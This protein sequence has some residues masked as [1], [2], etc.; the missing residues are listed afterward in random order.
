M[1]MRMAG[2]AALLISAGV[3][4]LAGCSSGSDP[5]SSPTSSETSVSPTQDTGCA[6]TD[7]SGQSSNKKLMA[8]ATAQY[9]SLECE[10][11]LTQQLKA[12]G[13]EPDLTKKS[14]AA[15]AEL[16]SGEA[17]GAVTLSFVDVENRTSCMITV[18]NTP[19]SKQMI[20]GDL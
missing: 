2:S 12:I 10:G 14:K 5:T 13:E 1:R 11:D 15:G 4:V 8:L 16:S 9:A 20:C 6:V 19:K 17:A 3:V 7:V 18:M